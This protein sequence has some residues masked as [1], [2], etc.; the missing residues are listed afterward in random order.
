MVDSP[1]INWKQAREET[2]IILEKFQDLVDLNLGPTD[3]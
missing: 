1:G 3:F 2:N